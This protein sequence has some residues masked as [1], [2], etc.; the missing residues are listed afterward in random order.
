MSKFYRC[1]VFL[2]QTSVCVCVCRQY[3]HV[4]RNLEHLCRRWQCCGGLGETANDI[5]SDF[6]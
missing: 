3:V 2:V 1:L 6:D 5:S 4:S